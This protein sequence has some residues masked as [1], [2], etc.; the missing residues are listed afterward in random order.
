MTEDRSYLQLFLALLAALILFRLVVLAVAPFPITPDEA[1][2]WLF[3]QD[4]AWGYYSKPPLLAWLIALSTSMIGDGPFGI[5]VFI[6]LLHAATAGLIFLSAQ[7]LFSPRVG[8][9]SGLLYATLPGVSFSSGLASTDPAM[10]T[11]WALAFYALVRLR[12]HQHTMW[13]VLFGVGLGLSLLGK[14][15]GIALLASALLYGL[16]S[17]EGRRMLTPGVIFPAFIAV[18][19]LLLPHLAWNW[20]NGFVTLTHLADNANLGGSLFHPDKLAAFFGAQF[21]VFGPLLFAALMV[22]VLTWRAQ[23]RGNDPMHLILCFAAPLLAVILMQALLSRAHANWAAP[24]YITASMAV[25]AWALASGRDWILTTSLTLYLTV[26]LALLAGTFAFEA[27][28]LPNWVDP[29]K[30]FRNGSELGVKLNA[31]LSPEDILLAADRKLM[32]LSLYH[33]RV[34]LAR[35]AF[36]NPD[37]APDN[38]FELKHALTEDIKGPFLYVERAGGLP[39]LTNHFEQV[40]QVGQVKVGPGHPVKLYRLEGFRGYGEGQK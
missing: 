23:A 32:A 31:M 30:K 40:S 29:A 10:M 25:A 35:S 2:Y 33:G 37:G 14:Y 11:G 22:I 6:P 12:E 3:A 19:V 26:A 1:Q 9:W 8:F 18:A 39:G 28:R 4:P 38:H 16:T 13:A 17:A 5:R 34:P 15:T 20:E 27:G 7:S 21:G 36:W 24:A